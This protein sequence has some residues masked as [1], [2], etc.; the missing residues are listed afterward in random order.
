MVEFKINIGDPKSKI[1]YKAELKSPD[2]DQ[3]LGKKIGQTFRGELLGLA[4]YEFQITG[5]SDK[6]GFPMH[7]S[8][9]SSGKARL[10]L[11]KGP[12]YKVPKKFKGRR[13]RKLVRGNTISPDIAQINCKVVKWG[14]E[15]LVKH[16]GVGGKKEET[17]T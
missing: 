2:A 11:S 17:K 13:E 3:L 8:V 10:L 12:G 15:D 16:F 5:G 1:T 4:G 14:E 6:A 9:E 7:P